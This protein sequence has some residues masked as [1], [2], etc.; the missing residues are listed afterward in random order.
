MKKKD[1]LQVQ[2][3]IPSPPFKAILDHVTSAEPSNRPKTIDYQNNLNPYESEYGPDWR[4]EVKN[5]SLHI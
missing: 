2:L 5:L 3:K 4:I 1:N